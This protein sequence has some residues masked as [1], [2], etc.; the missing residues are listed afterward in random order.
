[1]GTYIREIQE[2]LSFGNPAVDPKEMDVLFGKGHVGHPPALRDI[3]PIPEDEVALTK[4]VQSVLLHATPFGAFVATA[5][6][7]VLDMGNP[8]NK[9]GDYSGLVSVFSVPLP[10][11]E[12]FALVD[13]QAK[14]GNLS[15][16]S[17]S[18]VTSIWEIAEK[19]FKIA[20]GQD[21]I[22][23]DFFSQHGFSKEA[24]TM[25]LM[26]YTRVHEVSFCDTY[27]G[28]MREYDIDKIPEGVVRPA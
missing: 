8:K 6:R 7:S 14:F 12:W 11:D 17:Q 20:W 23:R 13:L 22:L 19:G 2:E 27:E 16:E 1:L 15:N 5:E 24:D 10:D 28:Y 9:M 3:H 26:P 4:L 21:R 25:L 18:I